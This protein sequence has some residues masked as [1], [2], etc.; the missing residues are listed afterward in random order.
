LSSSRSRWRDPLRHLG[1]LR[2]ARALGDAREQLIRSST[3]GSSKSVHVALLTVAGPRET[4]VLAHNP[5]KSTVAGLVM[6]GARSLWVDADDDDDDLELAHVPS[7]EASRSRSA[8]IP[9]RGGAMV[10]TPSYSGTRADVSALAEAC[11]DRDGAGVGDEPK[12]G[13]ARP[14][15]PLLSDEEVQTGQRHLGSRSG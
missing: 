13:P 2:V 8:P 7:A 3:N 11:H 9:P 10:F 15:V 5:H 1:G 14:R 6:S 4:I 12:P